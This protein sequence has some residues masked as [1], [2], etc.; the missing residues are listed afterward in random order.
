MKDYNV[1][2]D[3]KKFFDKPLKTDAKTYDNI[4]KPAA[5]QGDDYAISCFLN[6]AYAKNYY[7]MIAE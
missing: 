7:K 6:Y 4:Q 3:W 2:I 1:K 5:G